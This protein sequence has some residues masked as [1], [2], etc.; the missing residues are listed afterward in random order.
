MA[1]TIN[2]IPIK[3]TGDLSPEQDSDIRSLVER[4][5]SN[6]VA[7]VLREIDTRAARSLLAKR[8]DVENHLARLVRET[9]LARGISDLYKSEA[10]LSRRDYPPS[11]APNPIEAQTT[12]LRNAF[13]GKLHSFNEKLGRRPLPPGAE[14]WFAYPR[15]QAIAPTY[16]QAVEEALQA[17]AAKRRLDHRLRKRLGP[18]YLRQSTR[19]VVAEELLARQQGNADILIM[20][21]QF[22]LRHSG[23]SARRVTSILDGNEYGLGLF[24]LLSMLLT[25]PERMNSTT[26]MIDCSGDDYALE[27]HGYFGSHVPLL[28]YGM[29][30]ELSSFYSDRACDRWATPTAFLWTLPA[31]DGGDGK[32]PRDGQPVAS[33]DAA[34]AVPGAQPESESRGH[35]AV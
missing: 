10:V 35:D 19:T 22:G 14:G 28:D 17:L 34:K 11:Y 18:E 31:F 26:L 33:A 15:W 1:S 5:V 4:S 21:A 2:W 16:D 8:Q 7:E 25:H 12:V 23:A 29:G 30:I 6:A 24:A 32:T 3:I 27:G 13:P 9:L 20:P